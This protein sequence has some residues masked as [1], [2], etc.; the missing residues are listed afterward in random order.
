MGVGRCP[1]GGGWVGVG[2]GLGGGW[3]G[4]WYC[5]LLLYLSLLGEG[6]DIV[7]SFKK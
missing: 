4:V 1:L 6:S 5:K 3:V 2:W 7:S